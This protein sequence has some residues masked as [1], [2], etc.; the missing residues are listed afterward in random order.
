MS[1]LQ[2]HGE[3][4][5]CGCVENQ[6]VATYLTLPQAMLLCNLTAS[7]EGCKD[8]LQLGQDKMEGLNM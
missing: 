6:T 3:D 1:A 7:D 2:A 4:L 5:M 8:L